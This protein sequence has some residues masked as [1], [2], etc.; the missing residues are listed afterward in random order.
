MK[1]ITIGLIVGAIVTPLGACNSMERSISGRPRMERP[2]DVVYRFDNVRRTPRM[3]E[4][5]SIRR[6]L[7][8]HARGS[9]S[10]VDSNQRAYDQ[11]DL[12]DYVARFTIPDASHLAKINE[13]I[14][15]L[16]GE[17]VGG[18]RIRFA[19]TRADVSFAGDNVSTLN[20]SILSGIVSPAATVKLY[21]STIELE[22]RADQYGAWAKRV[23]VAPGQDYVYG[24]AESF[25]VAGSP[26]ARRYFK[27]NVF[28]MRSEDITQAQFEAR[29]RR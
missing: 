5:D 27:V 1:R 24:Y 18:E 19:M 29:P 4:W 6:I 15:A 11:V 3:N 12:R 26:A 2:V 13:E 9:V 22:T 14:D 20:D 23:K 25:A 17:S 21:P 10:V 8:L 16:A 7:Y 28:T